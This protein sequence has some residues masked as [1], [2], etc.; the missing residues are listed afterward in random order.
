MSFHTFHTVIFTSYI[1]LAEMLILY[2]S[3]QI[4]S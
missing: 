1:N 3:A 4:L 2:Y